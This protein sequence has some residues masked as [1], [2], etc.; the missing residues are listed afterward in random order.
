LI[1]YPNISIFYAI[2]N[3]QEIMPLPEH[4]YR[5]KRHW[6]KLFRLEQATFS[7]QILW[8]RFFWLTYS[9]SKPSLALKSGGAGVAGAF[10]IS[11]F[12]L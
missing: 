5:N 2:Y 9:Q 6:H 10:S 3:P 7:A 4:V 1:N 8:R 11:G 12:W